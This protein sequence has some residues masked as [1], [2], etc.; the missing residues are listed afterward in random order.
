M[1]QGS[2][3]REFR[4]LGEKQ[5]LLAMLISVLA[6]ASLFTVFTYITPILEN[7][8][9][10]TPHGVTLVLLLFGVGLTVGNLIGGRLADWKLMPTLIAVFVA[11]V[12]IVAGF[13]YT[14]R[15]FWP[16]VVTI[17]IWGLLAFAVV[18]LLQLRV[19]DMAHSAPNLAS[20]L[21]QGAFNFGNATG[22]WLGGAVI[23]R[24]A[25]YTSIPWVGA[26]VALAALGVALLS[27]YLERSALKGKRMSQ[28]TI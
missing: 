14:S 7:V 19:V 5:V 6:S 20:I 11:L 17:F 23:A 26:L 1:P 21:N 27:Q 13:S 3:A 18:P 22:A 4:V 12:V 9:G 10:V 24:G 16:A 2:I 25:G 28:T 15:M 8:T